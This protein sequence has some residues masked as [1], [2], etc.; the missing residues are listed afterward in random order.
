MRGYRTALEVIL[1][2]LLH[3]LT[4]RRSWL[5]RP[6]LGGGSEDGAALVPRCDANI[7]QVLTIPQKHLQFFLLK[8]WEKSQDYWKDTR[9]AEEDIRH[10]G[11]F[12]FLFGGQGGRGASERGNRTYERCF[13]ALGVR[14][15]DRGPRLIG[16]K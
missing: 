10:G 6:F 2:V 1:Q 8:E 12:F 13:R 9:E 3:C 15:D 16:D 5:G 4:A 7:V 11:R 14:H